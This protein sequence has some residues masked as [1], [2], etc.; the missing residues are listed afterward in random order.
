MSVNG[1]EQSGVPG[2]PDPLR[3]HQVARGTEPSIRDAQAQP[4]RPAPAQD[5]VEIS[6]AAR[7][8]SGAGGP[9][10]SHAVRGTTASAETITAD[11]VRTILARVNEG[12]YD[13]PE[14]QREIAQKLLP[15]LRQLTT[16]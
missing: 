15:D 11:R 7:S 8:L 9:E 1:I 12:F 3:T 16:G 5:R 4:S 10:A 14:Q 6:D 13:R 2:G